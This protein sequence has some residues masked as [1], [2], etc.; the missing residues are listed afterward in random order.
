VLLA[1][2]I[3][4]LS[5][6]V[7]V[8]FANLGVYEAG[9]AYGLTRVGVPLPVAITLATTHHALELLGISVSAAGYAFAIHVW[10]REPSTSRAVTG[11]SASPA[12]TIAPAP[13]STSSAPA[14]GA[15]AP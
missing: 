5:V 8:S 14:P 12:L 10:P 7:P 1:L 2:V 11:I 6:S 15:A 9:L 3:V 4:N 13:P